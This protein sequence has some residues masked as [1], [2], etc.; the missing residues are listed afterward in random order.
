MAASRQRLTLHLAPHMQ[1]KLEMR[2]LLAFEFTT[3]PH[4]C[5]L[6][7]FK[8][9][10]NFSTWPWHL[11]SFHLTCHLFPGYGR[12]VC[13]CVFHVSGRFGSA[14]LGPPRCQA[15]GS[16]VERSSG[17]EVQI[18]VEKL[19]EVGGCGSC[20]LKLDRLIAGWQNL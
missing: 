14:R 20:S 17:R 15:Q 3:V 2:K 12:C 1:I 10:P 6:V 7:W 16:A 8:D 9:R 5:G 19:Q 4:A 11:S 18:L 13:V